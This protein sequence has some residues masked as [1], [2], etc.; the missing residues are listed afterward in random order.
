M[1]P[2]AQEYM[3]VRWYAVLRYAMIKTASCIG[4]RLNEMNGAVPSAFYV[5]FY[6]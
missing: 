1:L 5:I 4:G 2:T 6:A 3:C